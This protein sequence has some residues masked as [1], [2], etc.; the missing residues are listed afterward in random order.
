MRERRQACDK[1][2]DGDRALGSTKMTGMMRCGRQRLTESLLWGYL[3]PL[4]AL[5]SDADD[6]D[7]VQVMVH[8]RY[9]RHEPRVASTP[10][11]GVCVVGHLQSVAVA[12]F[13]Y[14]LH[15]PDLIFSGCTALGRR[16]DFSSNTTC[17]E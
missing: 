3:L 11:T 5:C 1:D 6:G 7:C 17:S 9:R 4:Q 14:P 16:M 12:V 15:D 10:M 8:T 2:G 13:S